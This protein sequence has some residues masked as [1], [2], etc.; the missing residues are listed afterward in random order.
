MTCACKSRYICMWKMVT[1]A[2]QSHDVN[3]AYE[4]FIHDSSTDCVSA[5]MVSISIVMLHKIWS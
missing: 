5:I 4:R 1:F 2:Q 3:F